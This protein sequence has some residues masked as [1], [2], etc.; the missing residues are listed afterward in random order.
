MTPT[1]FVD[2]LKNLSSSGNTSE[3]ETLM[4][5]GSCGSNEWT[6]ED[7]E[8]FLDSCERYLIRGLKILTDGLS[9]CTSAIC[10]IAPQ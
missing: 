2:D 9:A 7:E 6:T 4:E 3:E 8:S 10:S 1:I 5:I